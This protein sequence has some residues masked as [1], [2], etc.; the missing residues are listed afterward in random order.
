MVSSI[1]RKDGQEDGRGG[2][3]S[4]MEA[5]EGKVR[6]CKPRYKKKKKPT[7]RAFSILVRH[8]ARSTNTEFANSFDRP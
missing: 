4:D 3:K 8:S 7:G 5:R 2:C 6:Q 1:D